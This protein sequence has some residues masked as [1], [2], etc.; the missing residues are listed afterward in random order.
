MLPF[1]FI[2]DC[3]GL[4]GEIHLWIFCR[5]Y[6][7]KDHT[8]IASERQSFELWYA[9]QTHLSIYL[10]VQRVL[11]CYHILMQS[12]I[13]NGFY[14]SHCIWIRFSISTWVYQRNNHW[15]F[16]YCVPNFSFSLLLFI[17]LVLF[18]VALLWDLK[19]EEKMGEQKALRWDLGDLVLDLLLCSFVT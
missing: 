17:S 3:V 2:W 4:S 19:Y 12:E 16:L 13:R 6:K 15:L 14:F 5:L 18:I 10:Y 1:L 7:L 8:Y 9:G 11:I